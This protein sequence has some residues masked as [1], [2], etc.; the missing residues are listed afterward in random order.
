MY[1]YEGLGSTSELFVFEVFRMNEFQHRISKQER[2]LTVVEPPRHFVKVGRPMLRQEPML[3]SH[4]PVPSAPRL[5]A[6]EMC[7]AA[8]VPISAT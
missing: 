4:N 3:S 5:A 7:D 6:F 2:I 8:S 1:I